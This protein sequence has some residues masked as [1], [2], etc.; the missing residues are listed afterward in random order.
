MVFKQKLIFILASRFFAT[1]LNFAC[2]KKNLSSDP[3]GHHLD[4]LGRDPL[5]DAIYKKG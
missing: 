4:K 3:E 2:G 1:S 5:D